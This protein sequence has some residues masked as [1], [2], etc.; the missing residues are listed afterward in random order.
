MTSESERLSV[1]TRVQSL[2]RELSEEEISAFVA[3]ADVLCAGDGSLPLPS[4]LPSY[5]QAFKTALLARSDAFNSV[6]NTLATV[7]FQSK[8]RLAQHLRQLHRDSLELF[9]PVAAI[10]AGAYLLTPEVSAAIGYKG[11]V[12]NYPGAEDIVD[13]LSDGILDPVIERGKRYI[14]A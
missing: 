4:A 2:P 11:Q 5:A 9:Q 10:S 14:E 12:R 7:P 13:D 3:V 6:A 1:P 8:A